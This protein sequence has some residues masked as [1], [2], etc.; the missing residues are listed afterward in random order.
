VPALCWGNEPG[1]ALHQK[2]ARAKISRGCKGETFWS[3]AFSPDGK[4]LATGTSLHLFAPRGD[5]LVWDLESGA[6]LQRLP[7]YGGGVGWVAF[8]P[9]GGTL[10]STGGGDVHA[11][12]YSA[13]ASLWDVRTGELRQTLPRST[14]VGMPLIFCPDGTIVARGTAGVYRWDISTGDLERVIDVDAGW[15]PSL[16]LSPDGR[17]LAS[18]HRDRTVRL[19]R[20]D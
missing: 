9:D 12:E 4:L 3:V 10:V 6:L 15:A 13:G 16:G 18:V 11:E 1:T 17:V 20:L 14:D 2:C 5:V 7:G 19:W 8:S